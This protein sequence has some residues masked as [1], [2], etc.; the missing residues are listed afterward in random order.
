MGSARKFTTG[1]SSHIS[2]SLNGM[3]PE[4]PQLDCFLSQNYGG[5]NLIPQNPSHLTILKTH[6]GRTSFTQKQHKGLEALFSRTMFP[7]TNLRKEL[8]VRLNL[9][10]KTI[11]VWFRNRRFKLRKQQKQQEQS[12]QQSSQVLQAKKNAP[13]SLR[14]STNPDFFPPVVLNFNSSLPCP[15]TSPS[16]CS[17]DFIFAESPEI[18]FHIH[19]P[20]L[21]RLESS[22]PVLFPDSYDITQVI[23]LYSFPDEWEASRC[24]FSCL[25][26]YLPPAR[27]QIEGQGISLS[28]CDGP[29]VGPA[30]GQTCIPSMMSQGSSA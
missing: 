29:A 9:Q 23:E 6:Q 4:Y 12:L 17:D 7:D 14:M 15:P 26:Q 21:E 1:L 8:A 5:R 11:K 25:Y 22:V 19:D 28:I 13:S 3:A 27:S 20:P 16:D 2:E 10:E 18:D 24:S 30:P